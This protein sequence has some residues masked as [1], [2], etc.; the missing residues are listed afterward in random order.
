MV[1]KRIQLPIKIFLMP[2]LRSAERALF[3]M[4]NTIQ[5]WTAK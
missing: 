2:S 3:S 4:L 5:K 1:G